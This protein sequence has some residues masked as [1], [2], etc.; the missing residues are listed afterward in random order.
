MVV[1]D[2]HGDW[3]AYCRYRDRFVV[4]QAAGHA[5]CLIF[6]GDLIHAEQ[7]GRDRSLD[8][9]LDVLKLRHTY[10]AAIIYLCGN[11]EIPHIYNFSLS[12]GDRVYTPDFE[13][14][15]A[16]SGRRDE[17]ITLFNSL[18]FYIRTKAG[19]S[20]TH[21]GA[22]PVT[23]TAENAGKL[24]TWSHQDLLNWAK[25]V[26]AGEDIDALRIGFTNSHQGIPYSTIAGYL[27]AVSGPDDPRYDDLLHGFFASNHPL[28]VKLLWPALFTRCEQQYGSADYAI[29]L[30]ALLKELSMDFFPQNFLIAGHI[31]VKGGHQIVTKHHLRLASAV[32]ASPRTAGQ[33]LLFNTTDPIKDIDDLTKCCENVYE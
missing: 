6:T 16:E 31:P 9:V 13:T 22:S 14:A 2:L 18:P 3:D 30:D 15:M 12:K 19:V 17:I 5:D 20:L 29:F 26:V 32:H 4:L 1:T 7:A 28:F 33:Y 11:H 25:R 10:G 27:L 24:F 23:I 8:I 21:A